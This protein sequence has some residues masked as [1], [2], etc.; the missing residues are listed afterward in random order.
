MH[1]FIHNQQLWGVKVPSRST[2]REIDFEEDEWFHDNQH[3]FD[4]KGNQ[5]PEFLFDFKD[6]GKD[7][8]DQQLKIG[9]KEDILIQ[10]IF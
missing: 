4:V 10:Y 9:E 1:L 8:T 6:I 7:E 5:W 3:V 2:T